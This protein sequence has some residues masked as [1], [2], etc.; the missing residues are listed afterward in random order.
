MGNRELA[1]L[2]TAMNIELK[3]V[4]EWLIANKLTLNTD[5]SKYMII[6]KRKVITDDEF[7][8]SLNDTL[9]ERCHSYK[10]LGV[11]IDDKLSWEPHIDYVCQKISKTCR[12]LTKLRHYLD[13]PMLRTVYYALVFPY[14]RYCNTSWGNAAQIHMEKLNRLHNKVIKIIAFAPYRG[15]DVTQIF[16]DLELLPTDEIYTLEVG[17]LMYKYKQNLLPKVF[18]GYFTTVSQ[19]HGHFTRSSARNDYRAPQ[20]RSNYGLNRLKNEGVKIW[21]GFSAEIRNSGNIKQFI[22]NVKTNL[23]CQR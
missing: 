22:T 10:Y 13:T 14:I 8:L 20:A 18:D 2:Q 5:K 19:T 12:F 3:K 6:S 7:K 16:F 21:N 1:T 17:K 11:F 9:L 4:H 15:S 23:L